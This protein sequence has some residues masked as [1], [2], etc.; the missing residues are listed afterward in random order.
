M[1]ACL[2][3]VLRRSCGPAAIFCLVLCG[4]SQ[5]PSVGSKNES[6]LH[7]PQAGFEV[8]RSDRPP[9]ARTLYSM[10]GILAGQGKDNESEFVLRRC[11]GQYPS[12]TP[13]YNRLAE[14]QMRQGRVHQAQD[15][16]LKALTIRPQD[17]VLRN[18][19]GMC[20]LVQQ[21]YER[22]LENFARAAGRVPE[23]GK[24]RA[25]MAAALGLL[26]RHEEALALLQQVLPEEQARSNAEL[27]QQAFE[28]QTTSEKSSG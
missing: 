10:A 22:A 11:I 14:L 7:N 23:S 8:Q 1:K 17:P 5:T 4:C 21:E 2:E 27:L 6:T 24:Y 26:G 9:S 28:K 18:N 12:F 20:Y 19:L 16:L 15:I 3:T 13:A 25:N